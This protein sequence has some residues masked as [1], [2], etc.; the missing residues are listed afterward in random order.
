MIQYWAMA[1]SAYS[2]NLRMRSTPAGAVGEDLHGE[3]HV[4]GVDAGHVPLDHGLAG[5]DQVGVSGGS[6]VAR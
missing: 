6:A 4:G 5:D 3:Q 1:A 2:A